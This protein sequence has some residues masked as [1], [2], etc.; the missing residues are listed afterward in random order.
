MKRIWVDKDKCV[1]CKTCEIQCAVERQS[2]AR[3]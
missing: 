3:H 2:E 1:G